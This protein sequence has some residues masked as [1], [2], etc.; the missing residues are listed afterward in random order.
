MCDCGCCQDTWQMRGCV[1]VMVV[2]VFSVALRQI[3]NF[4]SRLFSLC[5]LFSRA[6]CNSSTRVSSLP[7][8]S[9]P[10]PDP[11]L[12]FG[13][14]PRFLLGR[15]VGRWEKLSNNVVH[16][17]N[18]ICCAPPAEDSPVGGIVQN[19]CGGRRTINLAK[20]MAARKGGWDVG[21]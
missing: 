19:T 5:S 20:N 1:C 9:A 18:R 13:C 4:G 14:S 2:R 21:I 15:S 3:K 16:N 10:R 7:P 17:L 8:P 11:C 12:F 6:P